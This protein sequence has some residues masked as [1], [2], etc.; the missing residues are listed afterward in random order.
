MNAFGFRSE[1]EDYR[2]LGEDDFVIG[3]F[4]GS[5]AN[6][7][8]LLGGDTIVATLSE[9]R[10]ELAGRIRILNFGLGGYKQ[11]QQ[12]ILLRGRQLRA[13][14]SPPFRLGRTS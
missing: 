1:I 5:V 9:R 11:P 14:D 6:E 4:G 12:T 8:T 13:I 10:P 2:E 7:L 3:I